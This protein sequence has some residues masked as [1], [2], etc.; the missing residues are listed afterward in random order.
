MTAMTW[1]TEFCDRHH[2]LSENTLTLRKLFYG[3]ANDC[4]LHHVVL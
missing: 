2:Y 4:A 1:V 3:S